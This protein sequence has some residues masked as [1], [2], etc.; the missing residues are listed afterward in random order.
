MGSEI[1][2][3]EY[4][5]EMLED[6]INRLLIREEI[7]DDQNRYF[8]RLQAFYD[9]PFMHVSTRLICCLFCGAKL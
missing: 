9:A 1:E 4:C 3:S 6:M 8:V 2:M 7:H 5:C